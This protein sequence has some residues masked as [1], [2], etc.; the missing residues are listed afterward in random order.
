MLSDSPKLTDPGLSIVD[1]QPTRS[2]SI[3]PN[4]G[5]PTARRRSWRQHIVNFSAIS[6][7]S[8]DIVGRIPAMT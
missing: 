1:K 3:G 6:R 4:T 5:I 7:T 2:P 8:F